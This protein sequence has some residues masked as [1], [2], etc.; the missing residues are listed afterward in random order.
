VMVNKKIEI[1]IE[2]STIK[3]IIENKG[4]DEVD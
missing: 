3:K 2:M 1:T 4:E